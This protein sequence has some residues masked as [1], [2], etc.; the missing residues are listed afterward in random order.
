LREREDGAHDKTRDHESVH[1]RFLRKVWPFR[2]LAG[3]DG[4]YGDTS[5]FIG[6]GPDAF[7]ARVASVPMPKSEKARF[8]HMASPR[9]TPGRHYGLNG[10]I[11]RVAAGHSD[12]YHVK[13]GELAV[14]LRMGYRQQSPD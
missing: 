2:H 9:R 11:Q 13:C 5:V 1:E 3:T 14:L 7:L 4:R 8:E 10:R 6:T 12:N